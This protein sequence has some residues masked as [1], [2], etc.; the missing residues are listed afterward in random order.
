MKRSNLK[1]NLILLLTAL[2]WGFAFVAQSAGM[3]YVGPYTFNF[4]R[5]LIGAIVLI[6]VT[7][8][9]EKK[10]DNTRYYS[11]SV[12]KKSY[13]KTLLLG[14]VCCGLMLFGGS[15]FQ[16][17]GIMNTTASKA[18]FITAIYIVIVPILGMFLGKRT[19][20][21]SWA[22]VVV[23]VFGMYLLCITDGFSIQSGDLLVLICSIF[24][25]G[26][27]LV[28]DHFSTKVDCVKMSMIQFFACAMFNL[29]PM[30]IFEQPSI[31]SVLQAYVPILYAGVL[32]SGVGYTLQIVGQKN[33]NPVIAS[34]IMSLESVFAVI[35]GYILLSEEL[36]V[37][38]L[39]GCFIVFVAIIIAQI[40]DII[41]SKKNKMEV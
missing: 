24:F 26:H 15:A 25:A 27:I 3:D 19:N 18:G 40:P 6:P 29:I 2:I 28:I 12:E 7:K 14:G 32:S 30:I 21:F 1:S 9:I 41:T 31:S 4:T 11:N 20:L 10:N 33:S 35:G 8:V 13:T 16:Q 38:E 34:L 23:A 37:R 22:S 17:M 5:F 39:T 36:S